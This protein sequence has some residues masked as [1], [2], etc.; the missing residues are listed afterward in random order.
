[1]A[2]RPRSDVGWQHDDT[3]GPTRLQR[4]LVAR[5]LVGRFSEKCTGSRLK[6]QTNETLMT[7]TPSSR[8]MSV[9]N[10]TIGVSDAA[11][12]TWNARS[13]TLVNDGVPH[14]GANRGVVQQA[15]KHADAQEEH[16]HE[17]DQV[18]ISGRHRSGDGGQRGDD[19][20][21]PV[22]RISYRS[23]RRWRTQHTG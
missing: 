3:H 23:D 12:A 10:Q 11:S 17:A 9:R 20:T 19:V 14:A 6:W 13:T 22:R 8:R 18:G 15:D 7:E 5:R 4:T 21:R 2:S 16:G 1:M